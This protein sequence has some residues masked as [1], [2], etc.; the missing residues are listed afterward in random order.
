MTNAIQI[1][2][3]L[4]AL[5]LFIYGMVVM[6][7]A[8]QRLTGSRMRRAVGRVTRRPER[9]YLAGLTLTGILQ[10]SSAISVIAVSFAQVGLLRLSEAF[11]LL[12]GANV[13]TTVTGWLVALTISKPSLGNLALPMLAAALPF[14][15]L[16]RR[17]MRTVG[18]AIVGFSLMFVGL[19]LLKDGV[20]PIT[21]AGLAGFLDIFNGG[22][23]GS[24]LG[25]VLIGM[26][27]TAALQSSSAVMALII[28]LAAGGVITEFTGALVILGANIGT[29]STA[30]LASLVAG[31]EA[32]RVA[33]VHFLLNAVGVLLFLPL[34][35]PMLDL[36]RWFLEPGGVYLSE[37]GVFLAL[38]HTMFNVLVTT[39]FGIFPKPILWM[40]RRLVPG[41]G[42]RDFRS[43][44]V[45]ASAMDAPELQVLEAQRE[46]E[47]H[48]QL[49]VKMM[50]ELETMMGLLDT[51]KR[52]QSADH[53][54]ELRSLS[55]RYESELKA[56]LERLARSKISGATYRQVQFLLEWST[57][58]SQIVEL[59]H[60]FLE[61]QTERERNEVFFAPKQRKRLLSMLAELTLGMEAMGPL[62]G[63]VVLGRKS[64]RDQLNR[65]EMH[66]SSATVTREQMRTKHLEDARKNRYSIESGMTFN[67]MGNLLEEIG[68]R[69]GI[70]S[71]K[72]EEIF[73]ASSPKA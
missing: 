70:L 60:T 37:I 43:P 48:H 46:A 24:V 52:A 8:I 56:F 9:A 21:E 5:G 57:E 3:L 39:T 30:I 66:L 62:N 27:T 50:R 38:F 16:K 22:G 58:I 14:L 10:S 2:N 63:P 61:V 49:G 34:L 28:T 72:Y 71:S 67:E 69:M 31:R 65:V 73:M 42:V 54:R 36:V 40:A 4:G 59:L 20:P 1:L 11:F 19:G 13:G 35:R 12:L 68:L 64:A 53:I 44:L 29:T 15:F 55:G 41:E 23:V 7:G 47:H 32:R 26:V 33:A 51:A 45:T 18:E 17:R 25:A 6:S